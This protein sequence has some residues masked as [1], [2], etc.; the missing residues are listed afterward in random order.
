MIAMSRIINF[1]IQKIQSADAIE[2]IEC[3][4]HVI[5]AQ[6]KC[7]DIS[8]EI[9]FCPADDYC[10]VY[11]ESKEVVQLWSQ[12]SIVFA[13]NLPLFVWIKKRW[14][15]VLQ[16]EYGWDD[17]LLLAHFKASVSLDIIDE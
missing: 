4:L 16:G 2:H 15:V 1:Q 17:Y 10:N 6:D 3:L 9:D 7:H 14:I 8:I 5:Y 13:E 11:V 12:L